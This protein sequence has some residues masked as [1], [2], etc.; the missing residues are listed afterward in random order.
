VEQLVERELR[1]GGV[2]DRLE[3]LIDLALSAGGFVRLG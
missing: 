2:D 3:S 1:E